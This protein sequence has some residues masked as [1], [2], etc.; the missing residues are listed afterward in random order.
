MQQKETEQEDGKNRFVSQGFF[1]G[2]LVIFGGKFEIGTEI[3]E[4]IIPSLYY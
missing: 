4:P 1:L 3:L 2:I